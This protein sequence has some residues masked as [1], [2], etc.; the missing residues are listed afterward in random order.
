MASCSLPHPSWNMEK[1]L[2]DGLSHRDQ[3][4]WVSQRQMLQ[5]ARRKGLKMPSRMI[6]A[7][8]T[9]VFQHHLCPWDLSSGIVTTFLL[10]HHY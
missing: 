2:V 3:R 8:P 10:L 4:L 6:D 5:N 9:S 1:V 7:F